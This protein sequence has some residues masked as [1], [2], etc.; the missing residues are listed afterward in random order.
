MTHP[1]PHDWSLEAM[2]STHDD[3][4]P[5]L[6]ALIRERRKPMRRPSLLPLC[7]LDHL[8]KKEPQ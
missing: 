1:R 2:D 3:L 8:M 6:S 7:L 5:D 4:V